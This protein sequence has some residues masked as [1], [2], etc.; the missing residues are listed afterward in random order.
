MLVITRK[1][2]EGLVISGGITIRVL[3]IDKG[4]IRLGIDAPKDT[5]VDREE[6][7]LERQRDSR[8]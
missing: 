1:K 6:I 8:S 2:L 5:R 7:H 3:S 4:R